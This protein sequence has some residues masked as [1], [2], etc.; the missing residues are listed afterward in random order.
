MFSNT[1]SWNRLPSTVE[2]VP[3]SQ[4]KR[5]RVSTPPAFGSTYPPFPPLTSSPSSLGL[6]SLCYVNCFKLGASSLRLFSILVAFLPLFHAAHT[7]RPSPAQSLV[8]VLG[9]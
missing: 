1:A 7:C 6:A 4:E 8:F 2:T 5:A 9:Y 3:K